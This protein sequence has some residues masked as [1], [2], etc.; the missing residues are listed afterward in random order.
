MGRFS[1]FFVIGFFMVGAAANASIHETQSRLPVNGLEFASERAQLFSQDAEVTDWRQLP[2]HNHMLKYV[3]PSP[4][5]GGAGSCLYMALTG[6]AEWH[7]AKRSPRVSRAGDGP[8]DLSERALMNLAGVQEADNGVENWKTDSILL[9][10]QDDYA[11]RNIDYRFTKD[12]YG[13]DQNGRYT[14]AAPNSRGAYYGQTFN[15]INQLNV[16]NP[17][18]RA[19]MPKFRRDVIFADPASNQWNVGVA[20]RGLAQEVKK[21][22]RENNAPVLL[23]Y[24]HYGY[25]HAIGVYG[26]DE[27][28]ATECSFVEGN[29]R[30]FDRRP[31]ELRAEAAEETDANRKKRL[32][33]LANK[34]EQTGDKLELSYESRGRC[35]N[36]GVFYVRDSIY[37]DP[38]EAMYDFDLTQTG[39][40][41]HYSKR[42][43]LRSESFVDNM[44]NHAVQIFAQ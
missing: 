20:P 13:Y 16:E 38:S 43:I 5:Q 1:F 29:L 33:N 21:R 12:W 15:W 40:E 24:N 10:N 30:Y 2:G 8:I 42:I 17:A 27:N 18:R 9:F 41:E 23:I 35:N 14:P 11:I 7:L 44:V 31:V 19:R 26:Y 36:R 22:L 3:L 37:S 4:D 39:E 28:T 32:L 34:L 25:W 6:I